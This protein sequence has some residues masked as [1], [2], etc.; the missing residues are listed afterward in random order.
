MFDACVERENLEQDRL[1]FQ[2]HRGVLGLIS[3]H[4]E[5]KLAKDL[6]RLVDLLVGMYFLNCGNR[7]CW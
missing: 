5:N 3:P 7:T 1:T 6:S 4:Q 2:L